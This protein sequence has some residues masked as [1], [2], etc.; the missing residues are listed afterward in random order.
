[1]VSPLTATVL[2]PPMVELFHTVKNLKCL[3]V[4]PGKVWIPFKT[5]KGVEHQ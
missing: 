3:H 4:A 5:L 1:M 2:R